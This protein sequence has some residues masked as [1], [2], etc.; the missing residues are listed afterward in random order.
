MDEKDKKLLVLLQNDAKKTTKE[1]ASELNLSVTAV[2]ERIRKLERREILQKYVAIVDKAKIERNFTVLCHVKLVQHK[3]EYIAKFER[4]IM[5]FPEILE[6]WHVSGDYDYILKI[7]VRD[8]EDYRNFM[9]TKLTTMQ[10][11]ASTTSAF[12]IKEVKNTTVINI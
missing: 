2:F 6:C 3:K 1:L 11:I 5:D 10:H 9:V 8:I 7:C 12:S 4:E